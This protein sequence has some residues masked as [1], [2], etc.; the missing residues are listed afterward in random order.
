LVRLEVPDLVDLGDISSFPPVGLMYLAQALRK[1]NAEIEVS[2]LDCVPDSL[3]YERVADYVLAMD[4]QVVGLTSFTYTF[5]D[6]WQTAKAIKKIKPHV[7]IVIGGPHMYIFGHET[8]TH[9]CFDYGVIGDGEE[10]FAELCEAILD[11]TTVRLVPG[12]L[13]RQNG[14]VTGSG[15]ALIKDLDY[16]KTPAVDLIDPFKYYSTIGKTKAV[17]TICTSRGCPFRCTFC[18][19]TKVPYRMRKIEN[20]IKEIELYLDKGISDFF[21]FDDLFNITRNRVVEFSRTILER[22]L[23]IT[24]MFRG[25]VDQIDN[26]MMKLARKAGCHTVSVGVEDATDEGLKAIKK[27]ITIK[28]AYDAVKTIRAN[29]IFCSANWM[30]GLPSHKTRS[31]LDYLLQTAININ[32]N[33]A[34]FSILQ[35]LPGSELYDQAVSEGGITPSAWRDYVLNPKRKFSPPIWEHHLRREELFEFYSTAYRRYYMRPSFLL[36]ETLS[37]RSWEELNTKVRSF[38]SVFFL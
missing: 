4:P 17:G 27:H 1:K 5:Y 24:W 13:A 16:V 3:N 28:Q 10:V 23:K 37:V 11:N 20:V 19:V 21:L 32:S 12:L 8:M 18:M 29:K 6:V 15:V 7:P 2:I 33:Y 36:R 9:D 30:I 34:Q 38:M 26:D 31:H 25:R 35:C 22:N 14:E